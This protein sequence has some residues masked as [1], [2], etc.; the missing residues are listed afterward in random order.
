MFEF[1]FEDD[2]EGWETGFADLPENYN[3]EIYELESGYRALPSE[4]SGS[5]KAD[6]RITVM[7]FI[8]MNSQCRRLASAG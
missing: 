3:P 1:G 4:L 8:I 6:N 2:G 5:A 7:P